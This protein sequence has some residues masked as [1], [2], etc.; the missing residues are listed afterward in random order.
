MFKCPDPYRIA[1]P[2]NQDS[3]SSRSE[4]VARRPRGSHARL[5][6]SGKAVFL[7]HTHSSR[8]KSWNHAE[9]ETTLIIQTSIGS[10]TTFGKSI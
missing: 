4:A 9:N 7:L 3:I 6:S 5:Q 10:S 2:R 1:D 8:S